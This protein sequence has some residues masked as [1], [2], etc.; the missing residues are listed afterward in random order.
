MASDESE[1]IPDNELSEQEVS[2]AG[3]FQEVNYESDAPSEDM[4]VEEVGVENKN[5]NSSATTDRVTS[6][7]MT[8]YE[9][10]RILGTR[11]L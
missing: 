5:P 7:Y 9:R 10:A 1:D 4:Y 6:P 11:A 8:K 2:D 3:E